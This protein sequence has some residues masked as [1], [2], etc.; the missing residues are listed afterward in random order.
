MQKEDVLSTRKNELNTPNT[1]T[2]ESLTTLL[3]RLPA[4][5]ILQRL[6]T[7]MTGEEITARQATYYLYAQLSGVG[8]LLPYDIGSGWRVTLLYRLHC[9]GKSRHG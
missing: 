8:M 4:M 9:A 7:Q 5:L 2:G 3:S 1:L 6:Y